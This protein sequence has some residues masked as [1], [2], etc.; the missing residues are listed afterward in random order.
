[1]PFRS[2]KGQDPSVQNLTRTQGSSNL[3]ENIGESAGGGEVQPGTFVFDIVSGPAPET[4]R[5]IDLAT[6]NNYAYVFSGSTPYTIRS[7]NT[8]PV[9]VELV[10]GGGAGG[11]GGGGSSGSGGSSTN[12]G[13]SSIDGTPIGPAIAGGGNG[14]SGGS[15][16]GA[17]GGSGTGGTVNI[18]SSTMTWTTATTGDAGANGGG[19][20]P[21]GS[22]GQ[23]SEAANNYFLYSNTVG[24]GTGASGGTASGQPGPNGPGNGGGG[25]GAGSGAYLLG[26]FGFQSGQD[27]TITVG[28]S[29]NGGAGTN[30]D[31]GPL[32]QGQGG[33][34]GTATP[35]LVALQV[36]GEADSGAPVSPTPFGAIGGTKTQ[37]GDGFIYH[38]FTSSTA[39]FTVQTVNPADLGGNYIEILVQGNGGSGGAGS[40]PGPNTKPS[41]GGGGGATGLWTIP[42]TQTGD[43][44]ITIC[45]GRGAWPGGAQPF[46]VPFI[47]S[48]TTR[49][50]HHSDPT[51]YV[52]S[53]GG[54]PGQ[55]NG[56][57]NQYN[58]GSG[59]GQGIIDNWTP[60]GAVRQFFARAQDT[61]ENQAA[62]PQGTPFQ[63]GKAAGG[64]GTGG[65]PADVWWGPYMGGFN[66]SNQGNG[67]SYGGGGAGKEQRNSGNSGTGASGIIIIRYPANI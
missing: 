43:Y 52:Q 1:M 30:G 35:G 60:E 17:S 22:S 38:T 48:P 55:Y 2:S 28:Q 62:N 54:S 4:G 6:Q 33:A 32:G 19:G 12:G 26:H 45:Q 37:P 50:T 39:N 63:A 16:G 24:S 9:N 21:Q 61:T 47:G 13:D 25:G 46:D 14:G 64:Y 29:T 18:S 11:G 20:S 49:F 10:G 40:N 66:P 34:G 57:P 36:R 51:I 42:I 65:M 31:N 67:R 41:S 58:G 27:Y 5:T 53:N 8:F 56:S 44:P 59:A 15:G 23:D 7:T 3:G